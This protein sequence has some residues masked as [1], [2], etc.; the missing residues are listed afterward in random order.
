VGG[1]MYKFEQRVTQLGWKFKSADGTEYKWDTPISGNQWELQDK[2]GS[3]VATLNLRKSHP[4]ILEI[5]SKIDKS[6]RVLIF[7]ALVFSIVTV[8]SD[9][10]HYVN[11]LQKML[12]GW[13]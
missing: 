11:V 6:L 4:E 1:K 9:E 7:S 13:K 5:G 8:A 12:G 3:V 2:K 10:P